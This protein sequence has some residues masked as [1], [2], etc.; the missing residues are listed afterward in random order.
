MAHQLPGVASDI[1]GLVEVFTVDPGRALV[2]P[3]GQHSGSSL[4]K[5]PRWVT[6]TKDVTIH[7]PSAPLES[8]AVGHSH[9]SQNQPCSGHALAMSYASGKWRLF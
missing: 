3:D 6:L 5:L 2:E 9:P 7:P 8:A 4:Y 1:A